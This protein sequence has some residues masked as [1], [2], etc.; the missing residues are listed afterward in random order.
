MTPNKFKSMRKEM[1]LSQKEV[2]HIL[3]LKSDRAVR[4]YESGDREISG[5]IEELM[6]RVLKDFRNTSKLG[7]DVG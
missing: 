3:R 7:V 4:R 1:G 2:A 5:P 6:T